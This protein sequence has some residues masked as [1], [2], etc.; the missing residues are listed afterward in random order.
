MNAILR[1]HRQEKP[2]YIVDPEGR[3][4]SEDQRQSNTQTIKG[5]EDIDTIVRYLV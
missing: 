2:V 5:V 4:T 1:A 3:L